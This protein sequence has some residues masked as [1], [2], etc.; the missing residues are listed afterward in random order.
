M[1]ASKLQ[2]VL[3]NNAAIT[4]IVGQRV[5]LAPTKEPVYPHLV[6]E[7]QSDEPIVDLQGIASLTVQEWDVLCVSD[8]FTQ[9][10][11]LKTAVLNAMN[12]QNTDSNK[13]FYSTWLQSDY[14]Y[15]QEKEIHI[16]TLTFKISY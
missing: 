4:A 13:E 2:T 15:D 12:A 7:F 10:D 9:M 5:K 16:Q 6:Y 14:D 8:T 11:A 1:S 3:A